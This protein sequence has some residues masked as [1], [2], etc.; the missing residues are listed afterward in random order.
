MVVQLGG[1]PPTRI[2]SRLCLATVFADEID[3]DLVCSPFPFLTRL[4][5]LPVS[6]HVVLTLHV[7]AEG[8]RLYKSPADLPLQVQYWAFGLQLVLVHLLLQWVGISYYS[9]NGEFILGYLRHNFCRS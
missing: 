5:F 4:S 3:S 2:A 1:A 7:M 6:V 9:C 8:S